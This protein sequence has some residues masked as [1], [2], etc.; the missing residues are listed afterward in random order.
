MATVS[1]D[2]MEGAA[3]EEDESCEIYGGG[4]LCEML[5]EFGL[6]SD[7]VLSCISIDFNAS[8]VESLLVDL[9]DGLAVLFCDRKLF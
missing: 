8:S 1:G 2:D 3:I 9:L 4:I 6:D 5:T 7:A